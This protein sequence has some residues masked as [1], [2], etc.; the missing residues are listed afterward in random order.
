MR[1]ALILSVVVI[2]VG[3]GAHPAYAD[4]HLT[5]TR[6]CGEP[7]RTKAGKISR[8]KTVRL[9]F[10]RLYPLPP[11]YDRSKWQ[12]DHVIPIAAGGCDSVSNMQ[13]LPESIKTCA[14]DHCKDRWE[15]S[16]IYPIKR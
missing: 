16:G 14:D 10:E 9:E 12:V 2:M 15:R 1:L 11:G 4:N 6:Y 3:C 7:K 5:E 8:S 13:W